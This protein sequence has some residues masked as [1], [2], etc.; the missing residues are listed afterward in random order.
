MAKSKKKKIKTKVSSS[1]Q[2]SVSDEP[3]VETQHSESGKKKIE[4]NFY[5]SDVIKKTAPQ[6]FELAEAVAEEWVNDGNFQK[7]PL[8]HP[9][10]Q[11]VAAVSLKS[12]KQIEKKLE[13]RGVFM[14][15]K[16]GIDYAMAKWPFKENKI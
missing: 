9:L 13:E 10:A 12:A 3:Q 14:M 11:L 4:L 2:Q 15:A 7:L 16:V 5:G 1:R 6:A 8:N